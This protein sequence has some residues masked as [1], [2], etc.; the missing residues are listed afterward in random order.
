MTAVP[1]ELVSKERQNSPP[2]LVLCARAVSTRSSRPSP[3]SSFGSVAD[4]APEIGETMQLVIR[5]PF[6]AFFRSSW[7][8]SSVI[9][10]TALSAPRPR[11][12][13]RAWLRTRRSGIRDRTG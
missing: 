4:T 7:A 2:R 11:S 3:R 10:L 5:K 6:E 12:A 9:G 13:C 8:P 1:V